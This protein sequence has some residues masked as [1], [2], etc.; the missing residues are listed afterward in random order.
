M[1]KLFIKNHYKIY[2]F[3]RTLMSKY[4]SFC[5]PRCFKHLILLIIYRTINDIIRKEF[6]EYFSNSLL[7]LILMFFSKSL[8]LF[9]Y[10]L[11][12]TIIKSEKNNHDFNLNNEPKLLFFIFKTKL[13]ILF[14]II[15]YT[16]NALFASLN[17]EPLFFNYEMKK[18]SNLKENIELFTLFISFIISEK[19][20]LNIKM[21]NHHKLGLFLNLFSILSLI[22]LTIIKDFRGD[23]KYLFYVFIII[24]ESQILQ[25]FCFTLIKIL[26]YKYYINIYYIMFL[27]GFLGM[28]FLIIFDVVYLYIFKENILFNIQKTNHSTFSIIISFIIYCIC[29]CGLNCSYLKITEEVSPMYTMVGKGLSEFSIYV[30][31][32][33]L[34]EIKF[35]FK[36]SVFFFFSILGNSI[37]C[38]I[39]ILHFLNLDEFTVHKI[40]D[41]GEEDYKQDLCDYKE[42]KQESY[43]EESIFDLI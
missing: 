13:Y 25:T 40:A 33:V 21:F 22:V 5:K 20:F 38:E 2:I 12:K 18:F 19:I 7:R 8:A 35:S 15:I 14:I 43:V 30:S 39:I 4:F 10:L 11:Q 9:I 37:F 1:F 41:R 34:N 24:F 16:I 23:F 32:I 26:N 31:K 28:I 36:Q 29:T 6:P 42:C 3:L 17:Y 27:E